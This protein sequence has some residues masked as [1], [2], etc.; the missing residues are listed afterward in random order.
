[1]TAMDVWMLS[2]MGFVAS[3][4]LEFAALLWIKY[5]RGGNG[6]KGSSSKMDEVDKRCRRLDR[7]KIHKTKPNMLR[8]HCVAPI[9]SSHRSD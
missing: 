5:D 9:H 6:K 1:M 3:A 7:D 4:L 2:C 8:Q